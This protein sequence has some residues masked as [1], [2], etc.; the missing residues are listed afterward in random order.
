MDMRQS[1]LG[2]SLEALWSTVSSAVDSSFK[3]SYFLLG[4]YCN[5]VYSPFIVCPSFN[6]LVQQLDRCTPVE[7]EVRRK[8]DLLQ[9]RRMRGCGGDD[10]MK[11][12]FVSDG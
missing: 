5:C 12:S 1:R 2:P 10:S 8:I 3:L 11:K 9:I 4:E 7:I 6:P